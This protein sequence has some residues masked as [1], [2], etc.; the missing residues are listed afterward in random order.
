MGINEV[1]K[2]QCAT[3]YVID[4]LDKESS[5]AAQKVESLF[6]QKFYNGGDASANEVLEEINNL[7]NYISQKQNEYQQT[8][9]FLK[10]TD[11]E[12]NK[13]NEELEKEIF[14][15]TQRAEKDER[16]QKIFIQRAID[17]TNE[18][19]MN[20]KIEKEDMSGELARKIAKYNKIDPSILTSSNNL[21]SK[22]SRIS[23]LTNK[24]AS[25][26]DKANTIE[27]DS[28]LAQGT[29]VLMKNLMSKMSLG[30][31]N[32]TTSANER[33]VYTPTQQA[34]IDDLAQG[35]K[36][37]TGDGTYDKNSINNPQV[38]KLQEFLGL[39][40]NNQL[41]EN[42]VLTDS[43]LNQL[44]DAG[45][46]EKEALYAINWIFDKCNMNYK[47]GETWSVPYGHGEDA[48]KVYST[49]LDQTNKLWGSN[50][51]QEQE[52]TN[53]E[54]PEN[55]ASTTASKPADKKLSVDDVRT[56]PIGYSVGDV[57]YEFVTDRNNDGKFSGKN[58]F[59]G[60]LNGIDELIELDTNKDGIVDRDEINAKEN[61]FVLMTNHKTGSH[62]FMSANS[63]NIDS[64][65][66]NSLT[67]KNW[68]NINNNQVR[69]IFTVN[70]VT[71][72]KA[73]GY[74]TLDSDLY[75]NASYNGVDNADMYV[76]VDESAFRQ[77]NN[78][79]SQIKNI[80]TEE[81]ENIVANAEKS[82]RKTQTRVNQIDNEME[83]T[84]NQ[85]DNS[86]THVDRPE[87]KEEA[88]AREEQEAQEQAIAEEE[89][90]A[91]KEEQ[92]AKEEAEA[93]AKEDEKKAK[94][95]AEAQQ[96]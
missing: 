92:K 10:L 75:I 18:L 70:T 33:P 50:G 2:I 1:N 52:K 80:S 48:Q 30:T 72:E 85:A 44:K 71:G 56:D 40:G 83:T 59:M 46:D 6:S 35:V 54:T 26:I 45:F 4:N 14:E 64:I 51:Q 84:A 88:E 57:T 96:Q 38:A 81:Y 74:Q 91:K 42:G 27:T 62:G 41:N 63:G 61:L 94:E 8:Y 20:G 39:N 73:Q 82:T 32:R 47:P 21:T 5:Q 37:L 7:E 86:L 49:L 67:S 87:S 60:A 16:E 76:T 23:A 29:L 78:I 58:E 25:I 11:E 55:S 69:N 68:T 77:A 24:I 90:K 13:A 17:E 66:L 36:G 89:E 65:D 93:K 34:L 43:A 53:A 22:K 9:N 3:N 12:L 95:Q 31:S 19:Y 15:I 79:F 28:K